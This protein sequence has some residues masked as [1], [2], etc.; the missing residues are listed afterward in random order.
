MAGV[1]RSLPFDLTLSISNHPMSSKILMSRQTTHLRRLFFYLLGSYITWN[2][3]RM[4]AIGMD[5]SSSI[6]L[7]ILPFTSFGDWVWDFILLMI[8]VPWSTILFSRKFISQQSLLRSACLYWL[9]WCCWG[10]SRWALEVRY[11]LLL[12]LIVG[13][14]FGAYIFFMLEMALRFIL[15]AVG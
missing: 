14:S 6:D 15:L 7:G 5:F 12:L 4:Y 2:F 11:V 8:G 1:K 13:A 9:D 10:D 3:M